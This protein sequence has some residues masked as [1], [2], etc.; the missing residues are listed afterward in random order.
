[1]R[2]LAA[3]ILQVCMVGAQTPAMHAFVFQCVDDWVGRVVCRK[4]RDHVVHPNARVAV[5]RVR[6]RA[7]GCRGVGGT[8]GQ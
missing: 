8:I 5:G 7:T 3:G 4:Q 1:M 6:C 2:L